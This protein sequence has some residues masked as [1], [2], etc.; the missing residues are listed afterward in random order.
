MIKKGDEVRLIGDDVLER[1]G[2][3]VTSVTAAEIQDL[4]PVRIYAVDDVYQ[5]DASHLKGTIH[6]QGDSVSKWR[7]SSWFEPV[8]Q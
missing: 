8:A 6:L 3:D 4:S 1:E 7:H 5:G 2:Y